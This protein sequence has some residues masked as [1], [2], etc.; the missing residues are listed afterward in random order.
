LFWEYL[1]WANIMVEREFD[2]T[3]DI[4]TM[5]EHDMGELAIFLALSH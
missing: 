2:I 1:Q 5:L 3:F 4:E